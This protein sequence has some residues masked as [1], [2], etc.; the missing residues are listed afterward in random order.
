MNQVI[1]VEKKTWSSK[2]EV[3]VG[4][5]INNTTTGYEPLLVSTELSSPY[6]MFG[7]SHLV[8]RPHETYDGS[9]VR[10]L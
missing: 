4:W 7:E 1:K 5:N 3:S 9:L 8:S 6:L 2:Q 10:I